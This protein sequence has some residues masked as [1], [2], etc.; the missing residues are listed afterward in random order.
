VSLHSHTMHSEEG[1][2]IVPDWIAAA[3]SI[4]HEKGAALNFRNAFWTPPLTPRQAHSLEEEQIETQLQLPGLVSLTDHDD[5]GAGRLLRVLDRFHHAPIS[6]EWT[7]P[8]AP[9]FF[10]LG[11]HNIPPAEA[12]AI[13]GQLANFTANPHAG[14]LGGILTALNSCPDVLLVLN[15]PPWD[16]KGIGRNMHERALGSLLERHGRSIHALEVNGFRRWSENAR[17]LLMGRNLNLPVVAGC[18]R[19]GL[20]PNA[21][22][23]LSHANILSEFIHEVRYGASAA[24]FSCRS[25][26]SRAGCASCTLYIDVLRDYPGDFE[27]RR[28]RDH[29]AFDCSYTAVRPARAIDYPDERMMRD[30]VDRGR[31]SSARHKRIMSHRNRSYPT[32]LR[33]QSICIYS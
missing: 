16:E 27:G 14:K 3:L 10:H 33:A 4:D 11:V 12:G 6:T 30:A 29:Q 21:I 19:H 17:V 24:S 22:L 15:H 5:V 32:F 28:A 25:T 9:G 7:I 18:D 1:L 2:E 23:N 31:V 8:F 26:G 20:E 13:A